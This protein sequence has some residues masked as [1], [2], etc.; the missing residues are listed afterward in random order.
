MQ[1][2]YENDNLVTIIIIIIISIIINTNKIFMSCCV[3]RIIYT[4]LNM[5][6]TEDSIF[7]RTKCDFL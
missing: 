2:E 3:V 6:A 1:L 7:L 4:T 5:C